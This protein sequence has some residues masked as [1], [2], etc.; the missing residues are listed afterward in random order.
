MARVR[1]SQQPVQRLYPNEAADLI[2]RGEAIAVDVRS[3]D[4]YAAGHI[5]GALSIPLNEL[6]AARS[7][8]PY[9]QALIFYCT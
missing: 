9:A 6:A 2:R 5:P 4:L 3:P 1:P 7:T 8:L